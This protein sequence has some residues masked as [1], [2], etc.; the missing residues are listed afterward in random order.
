M[1]LFQSVSADVLT[2]L[3]DIAFSA[4]FKVRLESVCKIQ[5]KLGVRNKLKEMFLLILLSS[6]FVRLNTTSSEKFIIPTPPFLF[7]LP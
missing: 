5:I 7:I 3:K 6:I 2:D 4:E 1:F